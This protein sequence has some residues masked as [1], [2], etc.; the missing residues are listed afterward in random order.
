MGDDRTISV[1]AND[2]SRRPS[3]RAARRCADGARSTA[4]P[5]GTDLEVCRHSK[6]SAFMAAMA[7]SICSDVNSS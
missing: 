6:P 7:K 3:N 5:V 1:V 4:R 2:G